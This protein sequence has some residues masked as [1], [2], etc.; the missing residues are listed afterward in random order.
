VLA[1]RAEPTCAPWENARSLSA[2]GAHARRRFPEGMVR[3]ECPE[4]P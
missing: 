3:P 4:E 1:R 2:A